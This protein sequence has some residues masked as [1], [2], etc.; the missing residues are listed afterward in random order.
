MR[1]AA[2]LYSLALLPSTFG[3]LV[4]Y[5]PFTD[6]LFG[7]SDETL[8]VKRQQGCQNGYTAC[9]NLGAAEACCPPDTNCQ[10][11]PSGH[12]AC[13]PNGAA[14][15]G[16]VDVTVRGT[17]SITTSPATSVTSFT[18][19]STTIGPTT[20]FQTPGTITTGVAGGGSTVP[21]SFFPFISIP[22]SY[23]N[24]QL[25][26]GG[27]S[28]CQDQFTA[29][30]TSLAGVNGVTVSGVGLGITIEGATGLAVTTASS[31]CSSLSS[32][33][34]YGLTEASCTAAQQNDAPRPTACH[35][36]AYAAGAVVGVMGALV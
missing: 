9:L 6:P 17:S 14:C 4:E 7:H 5:S 25:C 2:L 30:L 33:A 19:P 22:T 3:I 18:T 36:M 24:A 23:A 21:N 28:Q 29:C 12:V 1:C 11:D 26:L 16:T 27:Y 15:T 34:C 8:L 31:I 32:R 35:G 10:L 13:C 20:T